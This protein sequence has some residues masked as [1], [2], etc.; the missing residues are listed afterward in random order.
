MRSTKSCSRSAEALD[1][2]QAVERLRRE[3]R[4][5]ARLKHPHIVAVYDCGQ[6]GT[7]HFIVCELI[8]GTTLAAAIGAAMTPQRAAH[9]V[10]QVA[11]ALDCAHGQ[12]LLHRDVKPANIMLHL[13]DRA[14]LVDFGLVRHGTALTQTGSI[15]GTLA[16]MAPEQLGDRAAQV[17]P[18][19][20]LYSL[21]VTL[22][23]L[24]TGEPPFQGPLEAV[25]AQILFQQRGR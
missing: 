17:G 19:S 22:Y 6:D 13:H 9:L 5:V 20:D 1:S 4:A 16:Y 23:H 14:I 8:E 24:L 2:A 25:A 15:L 3:A 11:D 7:Q 21:G 18:S 12:K 10:A